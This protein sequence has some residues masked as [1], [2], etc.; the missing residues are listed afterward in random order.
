VEGGQSVV[1]IYYK[2]EESMFKFLKEIS[3]ASRIS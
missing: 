2:G 3:K 1:G